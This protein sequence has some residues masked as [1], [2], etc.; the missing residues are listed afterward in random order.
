MLE[1]IIQGG[2]MMVFLILCSLSALAVIIDRGMAFLA[3][4]R[5]DN[6]SLRAKVL[7]CLS[8]DRIADAARLCLQTPGPISAV[9]LTGL[10]SYARH[11]AFTTRSESITVIMKEAMQDY[12]QHAMNAVEK[13]LNVLSTVGNA[14]PL[15]GM[16]GTV[17]GMI[18]SFKAIA[19]AGGLD[20]G[21]VAAG[22]SEALITTAA[23]LLIALFA[24][25]PYNVFTTMADKINLEIDETISE[26][27]DF[28]ATQVE[29]DH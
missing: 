11:K 3:H 15:F 27:L 1:K 9:L 10:Q 5:I 22:I 6:R 7:E 26:L 13:R 21:L 18:S 23:G 17:T 16:A 2:P 19:S 4:A 24:V 25:I 29:R 20:A 28:V 14:A 8:N 12:S